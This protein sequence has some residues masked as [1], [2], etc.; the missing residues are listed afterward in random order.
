MGRVTLGKVR[1]DRETLWEV[2]DDSVDSRGGPG[3]VGGPSER[4]ETGRDTL[5]EAWDGSGHL[6]GVQDG[7]G[8]H[9]RGVGRVGTP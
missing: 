4:F 3:G 5:R 8:H 6:E 2:R 1:D 9:Q 7:S